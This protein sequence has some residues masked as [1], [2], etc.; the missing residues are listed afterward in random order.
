LTTIRPHA[1]SPARHPHEALESDAS[2][3]VRQLLEIKLGLDLGDEP[4]SLSTGQ[5]NI[6]FPT[7]TTSRNSA[8]RA[9]GKCR[10]RT[11]QSR[12]ARTLATSP[13]GGV[14]EILRTHRATVTAESCSRYTVPRPRSST[15]ARRSEKARASAG[16]SPSRT[17]ASSNRRCT[18]SSLK[19]RA[20]VLNPASATMSW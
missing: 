7:A 4:H 11:T 16:R 19:A 13:G 14:V 10:S 9:F 18:A 15:R 12:N 1:P 5:N 8:R 17:R 2:S 6:S 3:P 20:S